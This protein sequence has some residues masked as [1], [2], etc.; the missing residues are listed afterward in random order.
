MPDYY[1]L[2]VAL[3]S[4]IVR[5]GALTMRS[6]LGRNRDADHFIIDPFLGSFLFGHVLFLTLDCS[7]RVCPRQHFDYT[8]IFPNQTFIEVFRIAVWN[9]KKVVVVMAITL[10]VTNA[11]FF[12]QCKSPFYPLMGH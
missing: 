9:R 8:T 11:A 10:W 7:S 3:T 2:E 1:N 5:I 4:E 6:S 12:I